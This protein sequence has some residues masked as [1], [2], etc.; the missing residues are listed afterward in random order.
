MKVFTNTS[1]IKNLFLLA[2]LLLG[3]TAFAQEEEEEEK[4]KI[5]FS[6]S[7]DAYYR[8]N[9]NGLNSAVPIVEAGEEVGEIPPTAPGS[10]FA[11]DNGFQ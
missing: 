3:S 8:T 7:V 11:N 9:F 1:Y 10:S 5:S 2:M 6:G 4:K